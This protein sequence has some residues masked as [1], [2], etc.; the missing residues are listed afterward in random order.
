MIVCRRWTLLA[1]PKCRGNPACYRI[2]G[3]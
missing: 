1:V 2:V 3:W